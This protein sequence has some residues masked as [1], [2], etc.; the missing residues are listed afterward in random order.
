MEE[1]TGA[2]ERSEKEKQFAKICESKSCNCET[3]RFE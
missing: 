1:R 3:K 2:Y